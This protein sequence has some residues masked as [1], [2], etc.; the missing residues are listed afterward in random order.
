MNQ[1]LSKLEKALE[2]QDKHLMYSK[3]FHNTI[4]EKV[5]NE[6]QQTLEPNS[7]KLSS[8]KEVNQKN[9]FILS[10]K[11]VLYE[12]HFQLKQLVELRI[13]V[14]AVVVERP[15]PRGHLRGGG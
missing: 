14:G 10:A 1:V 11:E 7:N 3:A 12:K 4:V 9:D 8:P 13:Q 2:L 5:K 6:L 15:S